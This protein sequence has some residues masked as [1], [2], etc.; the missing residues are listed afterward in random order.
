M[1]RYTVYLNTSITNGYSEYLYHLFSGL[2]DTVLCERIHSGL[3]VYTTDEGSSLIQELLVYGAICANVITQYIGCCIFDVLSPLATLYIVDNEDLM[4]ALRR[5][6][7]N[8]NI[9]LISEKRAKDLSETGD[10]C[11]S[12]AYLVYNYN[13][14]KRV[15]II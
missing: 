5:K 6:Y 3:N 10:G 2:K 15:T 14:I 11:E 7:P 9:M 8:R 13:T 4:Y 12:I 1:V